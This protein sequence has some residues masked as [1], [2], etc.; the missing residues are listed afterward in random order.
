MPGAGSKSPYLLLGVSRNNG[1]LEALVGIY[2][3]LWVA[4]CSGHYDCARSAP[5]R[6]GLHHC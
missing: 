5:P 2:V 3:P 4:V 1:G 6:P